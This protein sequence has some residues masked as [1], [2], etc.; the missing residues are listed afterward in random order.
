MIQLAA[1]SAHG[2]IVLPRARGVF[3]RAHARSVLTHVSLEHGRGVLGIIGAP[4]DGTTLLLDVI[5]GSTRPS[6]GR[7]AVF[8]GSADAARSRLARVSLA[9]P[10]PDELRVDE[11][12]DLAGDLRREPRR[13]A[14]DRLATL[15]V[16][17][18]APRRVGTL[19]LEERRAVALAIALSSS[20]EVLLVE[21]PLVAMD[22]VASSFVVDAIRMRAAT[23]CIVVTTASPRDASRVADRLAVLTAGVYSPLS[24]ELA[25]MTLGEER[26]ASTRIVVSPAAGR[27]GAAALVSVLGGSD[28]VA[29]V[30]TAAY[31]GGAVAVLVT[32]RDLERLSTA[33]TQSIA[34]SGVD[35]AM[36]EPDT[37]SLDA[38][39]MALAARA[40]S[41]PPGSLPPSAM[42]PPPGSLPP[43]SVPPA[44]I[45]PSGGTR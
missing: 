6:A 5:D 39:R 23:A 8:G 26:S 38:I 25:H 37:L 42:Q 7:V 18:L 31:A 24:P 45:P 35:V 32:G 27:A 9:A 43:G 12:C 29:R 20:A 40:M 16:G 10:L 41:P 22:S 1:V 4:K 19:T 14:S 36:V 13:P 2:R 28:A 33:V 30:E 3:G 17:N 15:G 44:S 11:I 21:E 34:T